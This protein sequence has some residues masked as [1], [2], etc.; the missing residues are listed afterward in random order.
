M[1]SKIGKKTIQRLITLLLF[2][3][4]FCLCT[5]QPTHIRVGLDRIDSIDSRLRGKRVGI[6]A[7]HTAVDTEGR[8]I[9]DVFNDL[10][11]CRVTALFGP[12]HGFDGVEMGGKVID[13]RMVTVHGI[14]I[15][16]LYGKQT[17]P[18]DAMMESVD[19]LVFDIQDIGARFFTYI[20]TMARVMETAAEHRK[21]FIVLDRP[22]PIGGHRMEGPILEPEF[23]SF[24][25]L[26]PIPVRHGLTVGELARMINGEGWLPGGLTVD[27]D[28]VA[29]EGWDRGLWLDNT[30]AQWIKPSPNMPSLAAATTY[31]GICLFEGTNISEGRGTMEPFLRIG[32]PWIDPGLILQGLTK[33]DLPGISIRPVSFTPHTLEGTAPY[34]KYEGQNCRGLELIVMDRDRFLPFHTALSLLRIIM[35]THPDSMQWK[36]SH[37]DR[38]CGTDKIRKMILNGYPVDQIEKTWAE[39]LDR[40][41]TRRLK[42]LLYD[43]AH[44]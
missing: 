26:F 21:P 38:L 12:E 19:V 25:G 24:V 34:P 3:A 29:M 22:N 20:S 35:H 5:P 2:I 43:D 36:P 23:A 14:P 15:Y 33:E 32:A 13:D 31:P 44:R 7:N 30:N 37:F 1:T 39:E 4:F 10:H 8:H 18:T 42:Y 9:V 6:V 17:K 16:S 40:F 11:G 28:V 27:L 41:R